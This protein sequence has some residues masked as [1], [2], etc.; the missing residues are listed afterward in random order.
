MINGH[1][2]AKW[3]KRLDC[4]SPVKRPSRIP[5]YEEHRPAGARIDI[6][7]SGGWQSQVLAE[8]KRGKE[9]LQV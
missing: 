9:R 4:P 8:H 3:T 2:P 1:N 6:M 7:H 5:V